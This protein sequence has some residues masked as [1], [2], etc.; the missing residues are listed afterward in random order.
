MVVGV[1][2]H[3]VVVD[4]SVGSEDDKVDSEGCC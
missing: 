1:V 4:D 3:D 2:V